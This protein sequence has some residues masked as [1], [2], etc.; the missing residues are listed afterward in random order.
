[1]KKIISITLLLITIINI[2]TITSRAETIS[3]AD[4]YS[5]KYST[6]LLKW[7]DINLEC[8]IVVYKKDGVEYPAYCLQR[9]LTGVSSDL[10]YSVSVDGLLTDV[11]VWRT[12]INGYPYKTIAQLGCK[13]EAEAFMAT[14]QAVYC[15]IYNRDLNEYTARN[16]AGERCLAAMKKIVNAAKKSKATKISSNINVKSENSKWEIDKINNEYVSQTF[17]VTAEA[18]MNTY[19]VKLNG[20]LPEG[21]KVTDINNKAK[22]QFKSGDKFKIIIPLK[23]VMSSDS[24][25][26]NVEGEVNTKPILYGKSGKSNLQDYALTAATYEEGTGSKKVYYTKNETKI[27]IIKKEGKTNNSLEGV[28]FQILDEKQ[29]ILYTGLKTDS[30]GK[31]QIDNMLPGKYYIKETKTKEG[32]VL[33]DKLIEIDLDLNEKITVN[34]INNEEIKTE[35]EIKETELTVENKLEEKIVETEIE[36]NIQKVEVEKNNSKNTTKTEE[37]VSKFKEDSKEE[38][39]EEIKNE[40]I[41]ET[42]EEITKETIKENTEK[43]SEEK[44]EVNKNTTIKE[45]TKTT[46]KLPKTGM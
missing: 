27:I 11:M 45:N 29:N 5:K 7:G 44:K 30:K 10:E 15:I 24:F 31:I 43:I 4:L 3:K 41:K 42:T 35:V 1:M 46:V 39:V 2:F 9:E 6:G 33:Y 38:F 19:T 18:P 26:I 28:E 34:V 17:K 37:S 32:Y 16:E 14:K 25:S 20:N 40:T 13:T 23:N 21:T 36:K 8:D 22:T 12:I